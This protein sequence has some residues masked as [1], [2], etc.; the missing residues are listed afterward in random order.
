MWCILLCFVL[1]A[2]LIAGIVYTRNYE[3]DFVAELDKKEHG[4]RFFYPLSLFLILE[5]P[6]RKSMEENGKQKEILSLLHVSE[7]K[8]LVQILYW[9]KKLS[10]C[11]LILSLFTGISFA[12]ELGKSGTNLLKE[13]GYFLRKEKGEGEEYVDIEVSADKQEKEIISVTIPERTYTQKEAKKALNEAEEYVKEHYLGENES[14]EMVTK[15]LTLM[16]HIPNSLIVVS[17]QV[18]DSICL[19]YD[20]EIDFTA[21]PKEG[22]I[23]DLLA[24]L[25]YEDLETELE[26][27]VHIQPKGEFTGRE[28]R[29]ALITAIEKAGEENSSEEKYMLP[30]TVLDKK[31]SYEENIESGAMT[32]FGIGIVVVIIIWIFYDK[33]LNDKRKKLDEQ[34]LMD[35][36]D[37]VNK[38][39]LLLGAG[40]TAGGAW[41][42]IAREYLQKK[43]KGKMNTRYAYEEWCMTWYEMQN[44][45]TEVN[46]LEHFG[47][48]I[49]LLPYLKFGSLLSQN[50]KK[51][52]KGLLELLEYEAL[53]AFE[54]RKQMT[55]RLAEEASTKLLAPMMVMLGLVM[56]IIMVPAMM[57]L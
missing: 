19:S 47:K 44:G 23:V 53:D 41:E 26:F 46:A 32:F 16:E 11:L 55:K 14:N 21:V 18:A 1:V 51:G 31:L 17:W 5:T 15:N 8:E 36:P 6:L 24:T 29:E 27:R 4:L 20:G 3:K 35:Y 28:W 52:S 38:F 40:M 22:E 39:T 37:L 45:V 56:V 9:C 49:Q 54:D 25:S 50:L 13:N 42:K 57:A 30:K 43:E 34:M 2:L 33:D 12:T 7:D 10:L 48:R